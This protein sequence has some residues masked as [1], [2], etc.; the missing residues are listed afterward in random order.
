MRR[1]KRKIGRRDAV[2]WDQPPRNKQRKQLFSDYSVVTLVTRPARWQNAAA[3]H[4]FKCHMSPHFLKEQP[5]WVPFGVKHG[6]FPQ[7]GKSN[8]AEFWT[9]SGYFYLPQGK[10]WNNCRQGRIS[11]WEWL[12]KPGAEP[13]EA[14]AIVSKQV[15]KTFLTQ[16]T[17]TTTASHMFLQLLEHAA[18]PTEEETWPLPREKEPLRD[19]RVVLSQQKEQELDK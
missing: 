10:K 14:S 12:N 19:G 18:P 7:S 11:G 17:W 5:L 9:K 4:T 13:S 8:H 16:I 6:E 15:E 2:F 3:R 1:W